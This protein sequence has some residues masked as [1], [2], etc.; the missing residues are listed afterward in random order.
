MSD[1]GHQVAIRNTIKFDERVCRR[2]DED[3]YGEDDRDN[4]QPNDGCQHDRARHHDAAFARGVATGGDFSRSTLISSAM[5]SC[6]PVILRKRVAASD[7]A[8]TVQRKII[9]PPRHRFT[10]RDSRRT[11]PMR[12]SI[13]FVVDS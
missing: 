5:P 2:R 12:F 13:A 3:G 7:T 10:R 9:L 4:D 6:A 8:V 11:E 1:V